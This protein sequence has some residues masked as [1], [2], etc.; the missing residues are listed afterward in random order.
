MLPYIILILLPILV[1]FIISCDKSIDIF[2]K[3]QNHKI[4]KLFWTLLLIL[5]VNRHEIVG[6]DLRV[7]KHIFNTISKSNWRN[8]LVRSAE[9][10]NNFLYK[11]VSVCTDNFQWIIAITA[12]LSVYFMYKS[13]IRYTEDASLTIAIFINL[14]S[15]SGIKL[16][17]LI[18]SK[19]PITSGFTFA[20]CSATI[21]KKHFAIS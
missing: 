13:Y 3:D 21:S 16:N 2:N 7:Y 5:L 1:H 4:M 10:G 17:L 6:R 8:A 20:A 14:S 19:W 12:V 18:T 11:I 15:F 9:V